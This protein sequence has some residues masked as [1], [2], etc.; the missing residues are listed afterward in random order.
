ME[1]KKEIQKQL[2]TNEKIHILLAALAG[3]G[4]GGVLGIIAYFQ[5]W[6]G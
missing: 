5:H 2:S 3:L 6:L 1:Q 4:A